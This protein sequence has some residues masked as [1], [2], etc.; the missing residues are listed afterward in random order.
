MTQAENKIIAENKLE[1]VFGGAFDPF[2]LGHMAIVEQLTQLDNKIPIRLVPNAN[3]P[4]KG[5][6]QASF[7]HR[8]NMLKLATSQLANIIIDSREADSSKPDDL[9]PDDLKPNYTIDTLRLLK[10]ELAPI[11][12]VLVIG[13]DNLLSLNSWHQSEMLS[14]HCHLLVVNRCGIT[15]DVM[16]Q[17]LSQTNFIIKDNFADLKSKNS[18]LAYCLDMPEKHHASMK[19]RQMLNNNQL[20]DSMLPES[21]IEYIKHNH[22]YEGVSR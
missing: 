8:I 6:T 16:M 7:F 3:P 14:K 13:A 12:F 19:I 17:T 18:G 20:L 15:Q 4:V 2:H 22:L 21:I 1:F 10:Q 5:K 11:S 9:K